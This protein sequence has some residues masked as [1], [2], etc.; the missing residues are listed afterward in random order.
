MIYWLPVEIVELMLHYCVITLHLKLSTA[1]VD[2]TQ[3]HV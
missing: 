2:L 3:M 1:F